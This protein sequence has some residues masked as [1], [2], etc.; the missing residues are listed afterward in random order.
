MA[1]ERSGRAAAVEHG[2][3]SRATARGRDEKA[4]RETA[5]RRK[6]RATN[7]AIVT[8]VG[9]SSKKSRVCLFVKNL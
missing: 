5:A 7:D 4:T 2:T 1:K 6:V 9:G 3:L 8:G